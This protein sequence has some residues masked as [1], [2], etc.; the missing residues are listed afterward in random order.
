[1]TLMLYGELDKET[2]PF[3][4]RA[5]TKAV[6]AYSG[7]MVID[8]GC[9]LVADTFGLAVLLKARHRYGAAIVNL[10]PAVEEAARKADDTGRFA[11]AEAIERDPSTA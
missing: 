3:A 4:R 9:V 11:R 1:V 10:S 6:G 8:V 7:P 2:A 5:I